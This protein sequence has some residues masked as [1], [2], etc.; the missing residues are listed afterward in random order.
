MVNH[1]V[2]R[3]C[4]ACKKRRKKCDEARPACKRCVKAHRTC[5]GYLDEGALIFRHF[6][7]PKIAYT[8]PVRWWSPDVPD[9]ELEESAIDMFIAEFVVEP[10]DRQKSRGFLDGMQILLN[11]VDP[12]SGLALAA[13]LVVLASIGNRTGR[14]SLLER[15][16]RQYVS[17]LRTYHKSLSMEED[18]VSIENLYTAVLLGLYEIIVTNNSTPSKH[19][20]HVRGVCAIL[21]GGHSP[22]DSKTGVR[23]YQMGNRLFRQSPVV[24]EAKC[25]LCA[26]IAHDSL[27]NLD[28]T[29]VKFGNLFYQANELLARESPSFEELLQLE[30]NAIALEEDFVSWGDFYSATW[31]PAQAGEVLE[32]TART[33]GCAYCHSGP[34]H[35]YSD[36]YVAATWN[37][38][39]KSQLTHIDL[40]VRLA[41]RLS[42]EAVILDLEKR[43]RKLVAD[44]VASIPY[45]LAYDLGEYLR[46]IETGA[47]SI[48]PNRPIG[49]LLLLHPL[50]AA[51]RCSVVP[52][53][54]RMYLSECLS[55]I[56]QDMGIGQA[57]QLAESARLGVAGGD[58]AT[59]ALEL[60]FQLPFQEMSEGHILIWA[61]MLLQPA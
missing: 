53:A 48:P 15:M 36:Y 59:R 49:G 16:E 56:G 50:Y 26:P 31:L 13:K 11:S 5:P 39:R 45:H 9:T 29:L 55:W 37:T 38:F 18:N 22:V 43:A 41:R 32:A 7:P 12:G 27:Q 23:M 46:L 52:V 19:T 42:H 58:R 40:L 8:S 17:L 57:T 21:A 2:S 4:E 44:I 10:A 20:A 61:G 28:A 1:G 30:E 6:E 24:L 34:V 35:S 33:S 14:R 54:S 3:G 47:P 60:P 51:A 25:V